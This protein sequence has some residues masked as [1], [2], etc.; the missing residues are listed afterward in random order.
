MA[1]FERF[2]RWQAEDFDAYMASKWASNR[3]NPD[4]GRVRE[5]LR[6]LVEQAVAADGG[7]A[8]GLEVWASRHDPCIFN[9]HA[10]RAQ[11]VLLTRPLAAREQLET[12]DSSLSASQPDRFHPHC[13]VRIDAD[14]FEILLR[15]PAEA[16][17]DAEVLSEE[18]TAHARELAALL[19]A[20]PGP[21]PVD[22][23]RRWARAD[24]LGWD[25]P[26]APV[27]DWLG[28]AVPMLRNLLRPIE[29]VPAKPVAE[30]DTRPGPARTQ[31]PPRPYQPYRPQAPAAPRPRTVAERPSLERILPLGARQALEASLQ[32]AEPRREE[33]E[34]PRD[35]TAVGQRPAYPQ[36]A[37]P[38]R[39]VQGPG[40]PRSAPHDRGAALAGPGRGPQ[41]HGGG[42]HGAARP[43]LPAATRPPQALASPAGRGGPV[44][45]ERVALTGGLLAGKEGVCIGP[46]GPGKFK[47][48]VGALQFDVPVQQLTPA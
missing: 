38:E 14:G 37:N 21:A 31:A 30:T 9:Q 48:Q 25:D 12:A 10:V 40:Q 43:P 5:R 2:E 6:S 35:R 44:A 23:V 32:P 18:R 41:H 13:G 34:P 28:L 39:G 33:R 16:V 8:D 3:F 15:L 1:L 36:R 45:G 27:A 46:A 26:M 22:V 20:D 11:T 24:V 4:R 47:I 29:Q 17:F 42:G 7:L 19:G